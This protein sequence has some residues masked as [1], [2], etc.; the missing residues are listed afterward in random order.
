[1]ILD[2]LDPVHVE[3]EV[4]GFQVPRLRRQVPTTYIMLSDRQPFAS[5]IP[6]ADPAWYSTLDS[7]YYN[8]SHVRLAKYLRKYVDEELS[9]LSEQWEREQMVPIAVQERHA[10]IGCLAVSI[11]PLAREYMSDI[12][13]PGGIKLDEWDAFHD[14]VLVD[15]LTR[16]GYLGVNWAL[17]TGPTIA[18]PL[19]NSYANKQLKA[20][21]LP[22]ILKGHKRIAL[23]VTEPSGGS[24]VAGIQTTAV[25]QGDDYIVNGMKKWITNAKNAHYVVAAV[26]TGGPGPTGVSCLVIPMDLPGVTRRSI[27]NS[28]VAASGSTHITFE[29]VKVPRKY[30]IGK[31]GEG[32]RMFLSNFNHERLVLSMQALRLSRVCIEDAYEH[33]CVRKTF[34]KTLIEQPVIRAKFAEMGWRVSSVQTQLESIYY[35]FN[36]NHSDADLASVVALAKVQATRC[37]EYCNREAQQVFGGLGYQRGTQ[38]GGRV[39]QISRDL[40]VLAVGGGSDE[41]MID[42][43]IKQQMRMMTALANNEKKP[44]K[45]QDAIPKL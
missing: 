11:F 31:E 29:D 3:A 21:L 42:L 22:P 45:V 23:A 33:A 18:T 4:P 17:A 27:Q 15:E 35:H 28:G 13:L 9:P 39:E 38:R 30:L 44:E 7:P 12:P 37:L 40:R 14:L 26:R 25:K 43:G 20:E 5:P 1:M 36:R 6:F 19:I 2:L 34:G 41:I 10:A 8:D 16:G 32:L 24:D